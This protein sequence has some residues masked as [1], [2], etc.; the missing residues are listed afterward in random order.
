MLADSLSDYNDALRKDIEHYSSFKSIKYPKEII[1]RINKCIDDL[2]KI[3]E[4]IDCSD[5]ECLQKS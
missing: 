1:D 5:I 2:D 4:E 3:R